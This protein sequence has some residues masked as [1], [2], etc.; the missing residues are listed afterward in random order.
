MTTLPGDAELHPKIRRAYFW[1]L[2]GNT[3]RHF[4]GFAISV[5]LARLLE[6]SDYGLIG[7][8]LVVLSLLATFQDLGL[9]QAMVHFDEQ[10]TTIP[11]YFTATVLVG[12]ILTGA[13]I[14]AAP[15]VAAFYHEPR[16]TLVLRVLSVTVLLI[17]SYTISQ[18]VLSKQFRFKELA[19]IEACASLS[20]GG[21]GVFLAWRGAGVWSLVINLLLFNLF[22]TVALCALVPPRF[23]LRLDKPVLLRLL[24]YGLPLTGAN[25]LHQFYDNADYLVVGRMVGPTPLGH[26]TQAFR[27][28]TLAHERI[29]ALVNR[30]AFPS[31]AAMQKE[32]DRVVEHW[33]SVS[34]MVSLVNFPLLSFLFVNASDLILLILGRKWLPA[35]VPLRFLCV[36]GVLR[37]LVHIILHIQNALGQ[38]RLRLWFSIANLVLL[39]VSF[40]IGCKLAGIKGVG[41]AWCV[42]YPVIWMIALLSVRRFLPFSFAGYFKRLRLPALTGALCIAS[43]MLAGWPSQLLSRLI[44]RAAVGGAV[45]GACLLSAKDIRGAAI[46]LFRRMVCAKA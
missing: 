37:S 35:A 41:I 13:A 43:M 29:A 14:L 34:R 39:P 6:P 21:I 45:A 18:A 16:L 10:R 32:P 46:G 40:A 12:S 17:S 8:V 33:F 30:V 42:V 5:L 15:A 20:A 22:Q 2:V 11:T 38:T 28:A 26:Y 23:T 44:L 25:L 24:R 3:L 7:M 36:V 19:L 9:G 4:G 1:T 31:F 27:L